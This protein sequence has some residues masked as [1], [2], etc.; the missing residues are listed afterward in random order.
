MNFHQNIL[1]TLT[2]QHKDK[3]PKLQNTY[4]PHKI[5]QKNS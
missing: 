4:E 2:D 3:N 5:R 1:I